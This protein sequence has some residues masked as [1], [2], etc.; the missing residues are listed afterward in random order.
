MF[1]T[2]GEF[3]KLII[4]DQQTVCICI[5][6]HSAESYFHH[7]PS[8]IILQDKASLS[9]SNSAYNSGNVQS[10]FS[11]IMQKLQ[12]RSVSFASDLECFT[13][14]G[15][16]TNSWGSIQAFLSKEYSYV[17]AVI[18]YEWFTNFGS[19]AQPSLFS[20]YRTYCG[21]SCSSCVPICSVNGV[22]LS[23]GEDGCGGSCGS[24]DFFLSFLC[25]FCERKPFIKGE[26]DRMRKKLRNRETTKKQ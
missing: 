2:M 5:L 10:A 13:G 8:T 1:R 12:A 23:C 21:S 14:T 20:D 24:C 4:I 7:S 15:S 11:Q 18:A 22:S 3:I 17:S 9:A 26:P 19:F 6:F 25:Y 16:A